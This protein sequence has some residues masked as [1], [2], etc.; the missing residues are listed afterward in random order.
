M[1]DLVSIIDQDPRFHALQRARSRLAWGLTA[2]V[3]CYYYGL[4][5]T[6]AFR[7]HV[8][9]HRLHADTVVTVGIFCGVAIILLSILLTGLYVWRANRE[10]DRLNQDILDE[11][12][13]AQS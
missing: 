6:I 4:I 13:R 5:L 1:Q 3:V 7:P 11:A 8:L 10:F 12:T 2:L 9:A